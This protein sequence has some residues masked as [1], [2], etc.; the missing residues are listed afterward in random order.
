MGGSHPNFPSENPSINTFWTDS[1]PPGPWRKHIAHSK[2][3]SNALFQNYST[4]EKGD[5]KLTDGNHKSPDSDVPKLSTKSCSP[6]LKHSPAPTALNK[7]QSEPKLLHRKY[8]TSNPTAV[9]RATRLPSWFTKSENLDKWD[10]ETV[11]IEKVAN[12][13]SWVKDPD[14][15]DTSTGFER[16]TNRWNRLNFVQNVRNR[17]KSIQSSLKM[18]KHEKERKEQEYTSPAT[19]HESIFSMNHVY[20]GFQH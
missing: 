12:L 14:K 20:Y 16:T 10:P 6:F 15:S 4:L 5:G 13:P 11:E 2:C 3:T 18:K 17:L 7:V 9:N 8:Q 1:I 19:L